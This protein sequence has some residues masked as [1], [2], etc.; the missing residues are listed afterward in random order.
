MTAVGMAGL[1][2]TRWVCL[3]QLSTRRSDA[4]PTFLR[5]AGPLHAGA[6]II[7]LDS[8]RT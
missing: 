3:G 7:E 6:S 4:L 2:A 1:A 8:V 5:A